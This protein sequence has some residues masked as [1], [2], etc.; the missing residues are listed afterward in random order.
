[1][2]NPT[3]CFYYFTRYYLTIYILQILIICNLL[4]ALPLLNSS[5]ELLI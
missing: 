3:V 5:A 1:M 2:V 4:I